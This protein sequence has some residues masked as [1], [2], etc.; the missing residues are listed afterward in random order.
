VDL[1]GRPSLDAPSA[2]AIAHDEFIAGAASTM[3]HEIIDHCART[4]AG[5]FAAPVETLVCGVWG[6]R[7]DPTAHCM[8]TEQRLRQ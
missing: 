6:I 3:A 7:N 4:G 2:L 1:P 5:N 8:T